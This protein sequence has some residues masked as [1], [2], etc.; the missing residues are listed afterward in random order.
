MNDILVLL[1]LL[2]LVFGLSQASS[3]TESEGVEI[4][5]LEP[6]TDE[7]ENPKYEQ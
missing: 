2:V 4:Q 3:Q 1:F 6:K 5:T 7:P